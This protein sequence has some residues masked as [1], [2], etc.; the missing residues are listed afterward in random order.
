MKVVKICGIFEAIALLENGK[1][2]DKWLVSILHS[3]DC[4]ENRAV[5]SRYDR[6]RGALR[7]DFDDVFR[8]TA[9]SR[10]P[11]AEDVRRVLEWAKDK[12]E[13][14]VHCH[15]GY[16]RSAAVAYLI[17]CLAVGPHEALKVLDY[18]KQCPN[19]LVVELGAEVMN[20][21][22]VLDAYWEWRDEF[23]RLWLAEL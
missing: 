9:D 10:E 23:D 19:E 5:V 2:E 17:E 7:L 12:S 8:V 1:L 3:K 18:K 21:A 4:I 13:I 22:C 14:V 11:R 20:D 16:S 6:C 15:A